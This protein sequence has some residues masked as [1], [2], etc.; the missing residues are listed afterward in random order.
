MGRV[1]FFGINWD[2]ILFVYVLLLIILILLGS[3]GIFDVLGK[4]LY[5]YCVIDLF[6]N[7][8]I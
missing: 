1:L 4:L 2:N 3:S 6:V 7:N 8:Y 5:F